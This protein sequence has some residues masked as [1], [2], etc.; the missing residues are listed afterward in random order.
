L[1]LKNPRNLRL[2]SQKGSV[3]IVEKRH[4]TA[5]DLYQLKIL[6]DP[7]ISPNGRYVIYTVQTTDAKTEQKQSHLWLVPTDGSAPPRQFTFGKR[8]DSHPRWSPDGRSLAFLSNRDDEKQ[9]QLYLIGLDGGEARPLTKLNGAVATFAWSPDGTRLVCQF[10][11]KDPAVRSARKT[12]R[13]RSS[14]SSPGAS[15]AWNSA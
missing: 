4:I 5:E 11:Q 3:P 7:Q 6:G 9:A 10:R 14:A 2:K 8:R 1:L 12:S 15:P 13:K